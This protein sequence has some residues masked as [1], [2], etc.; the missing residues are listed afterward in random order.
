MCASP[1]L[2]PSVTL[3][4]YS[5]KWTNIVVRHWCTRMPINS[6][7]IVLKRPF[8]LFVVVLFLSHRRYTSIPADKHYHKLNN[9]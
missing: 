7:I 1:E 5:R 8:V 3:A 2:A 9:A 6:V 4:R